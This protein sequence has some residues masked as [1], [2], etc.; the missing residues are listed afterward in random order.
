MLNTRRDFLK[1]TGAGA[2]G[3]LLARRSGS[4]AQGRREI[5]IARKRV[6]VIDVHAH[7]F[8]S[9]VNEI[10]KGTNVSSSGQNSGPLLVLGP[11]RLETMDRQGVDV[12]VL[13]I[14]EFWYGAA[15]R[16]LAD[17]IVRFQNEKMAEWCAAHPDR[18]RGFASVALQHPDMAAAQLDDAIKRLKL[19]GVAIGGSAGGE[20]LS[21]PR[22]D[23]FWAECQELGAFVFMHPQPAPGTTQNPRLQGR[24][25]LGNVIGNPL[26]TTVF[27]SHMIFE[28]TM[29]KFPRLKICAPHGGGFLASYSGRM[30][31]VC[32]RGGGGGADCRSLKK[33]PSEYFK[34]EI[35]S[36]TIVFHDEGLRH[37]IAECGVSQI[38]FGTDYPFD[39]PVN[40]D[41]ILNAAFL[42]D[43][44]KEAILG[45]N[46]A[47]LLKI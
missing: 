27:L 13:S 14:N 47:K 38:V 17:R 20:E 33:K 25:G 26:E 8:F 43:A 23:P 22:F 41:F 4:T 11:G 10:L 21:N 28:G 1:A 39:W 18:F 7:C 45:G 36:D 3:L 31:A 16:Q 44:D 24:G 37:L 32:G 34:S 15:D 5:S 9:E 35:Y 6:Q 12:E 19:S 40:V 2:A 29:D 42:S 46:A 30:D